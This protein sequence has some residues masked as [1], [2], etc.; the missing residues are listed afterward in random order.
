M[1]RVLF[2]LAAIAVLA[3]LTGCTAAPTPPTTEAP[4][5]TTAPAATE[6]LTEPEQALAPMALA[7]LQTLVEGL[8]TADATVTYLNMGK[9]DTHRAAAAIRTDRYLAALQ[10]F[11]WEPFDTPI[12]GKADLTPQCTL[13]GGSFSMTSYSDFYVTDARPLYVATDT[14]GGWFQL[15]SLEETEDTPAQVPGMLF[16]LF[17][18]WYEEATFAELHQNGG[19]PSPPTSWT[20][21]KP[22]PP[23]KNATTMKPTTTAGSVPPRFPASSPPVTTTRATWMSTNFCNTARP[24]KCSTKRTRKNFNK[25]RKSWACEAAA[26]ANC[27]PSPNPR[28]LA[29]ACPA[30]TS[31][32]S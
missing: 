28:F 24:K 15:A 22:S 17:N 18:A 5:V 20:G 29:A 4:P 30:P 10:G 23:P 19:R 31:T 2:F 6:A 7:D 3:A 26:L 8:T 14:T 25:Y 11:V 12:Q 27:S 21:S 13:T 16:E 9:A 32:R 1:R